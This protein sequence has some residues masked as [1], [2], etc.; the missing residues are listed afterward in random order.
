MLISILNKIKKSEIVI[1]MG[2]FNANVGS[3]NTNFELAMG[4]HGM[5]TMNDNGSRLMELCLDQELV[6]GGILFPHKA[7]YK[8]T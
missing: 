8:L 2:D 6:V 3:D 7:I 4:T 1:I 5:G